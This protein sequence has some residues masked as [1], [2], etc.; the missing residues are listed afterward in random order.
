MSS[1]A[2]KK[3]RL[4]RQLNLGCSLSLSA[5]RNLRRIRRLE[6]SREHFFRMRLNLIYARRL[7]TA[8]CDEWT[9]LRMRNKSRQDLFRH[10]CKLFGQLF[11][12]SW[13]TLP[14]SWNKM[15][16]FWTAKRMMSPALVFL[17]LNCF[18]KRHQKKETLLAKVF[19]VVSSKAIAQMI[20]K[21]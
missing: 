2:A 1:L 14:R 17:E 3:L 7:Q 8:G 13:K 18:L 20:S 15:R 21:S 12:Q 5:A 9:V 10:S 11:V 4:T 16:R 19:L 6:K